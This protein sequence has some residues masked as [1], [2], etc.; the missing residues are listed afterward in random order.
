MGE[1]GKFRHVGKT[2]AISSE[3]SMIKYCGSG[4]AAAR[5]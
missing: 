5:N 4:I 3:P 2:M 1:F